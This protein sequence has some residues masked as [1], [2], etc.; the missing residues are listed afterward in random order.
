M[1]NRPSV[2]TISANIK[3]IRALASSA[4]PPTQGEV[5]RMRDLADEAMS[6]ALARQLE[7]RQVPAR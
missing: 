7:I 4:H 1:K 2:I 6:A 5:G 3:A